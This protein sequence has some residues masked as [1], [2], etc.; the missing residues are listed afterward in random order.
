MAVG[1]DAW[2][3]LLELARDLRAELDDHARSAAGLPEGPA[4]ELPPPPPMVSAGGGRGAAARREGG[5]PA[6]APRRPEPRPAPDPASIPGIH[7]AG[8]AA[9]PA[10]PP[11][12]VPHRSP[13]SAAERGEVLRAIR[14][15]L[16]DC[17][18]CRLASGRTTLVFSD[19]SPDAKVMFVGEAP[20]ADEDRR[21]VPFVGAAG[22][23]LTDIIE[24][25]LRIPRE[26]VYI[27]NVVK[28]RPPGNRDPGAD[29]VETCGPFLMRQIEAVE[30]LILVALGR[31]AVQTLL[32]SQAPISRMR[33]RFHRFGAG[34]SLMPT[35]HPAYLLRNPA[36]KRLVFEDMVMVRGEYER[37]T[38]TTLPPVRSR[39]GG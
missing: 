26:E 9:A 37:L 16:G 22:Q 19:G 11:S 24:N 36:D 33:G 10:R 2:G 25:V 23:M 1:T 29:E 14:E 34:I 28:C 15:D 5:P 30:P 32:R 35:Y 39:R 17:Q 21:G 27:A 12:P 6:A 13:R 18:R 38:G 7:P 4:P 20:G 3:E 31:F 8:L